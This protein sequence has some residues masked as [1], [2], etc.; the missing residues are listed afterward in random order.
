M[1]PTGKVEPKYYLK[2]LSSLW[3]NK[4]LCVGRYKEDNEGI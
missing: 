1:Y 4:C 3:K 2:V